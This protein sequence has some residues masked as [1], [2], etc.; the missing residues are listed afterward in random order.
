MTTATALGEYQEKRRF[1]FHAGVAALLLLVE[2]VMLPFL[3]YNRKINYVRYSQICAVL[4]FV[5]VKYFYMENIGN[6]AGILRI[7]VNLR[8]C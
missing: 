2:F 6:L 3:D 5:V 1:L 8:I 7:F 4:K